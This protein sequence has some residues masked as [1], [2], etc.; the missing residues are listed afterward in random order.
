MS[1]KKAALINAI[2][3]YSTIIFQIAVNIILSRTLSASEYGVVAV[4]TTFSTFFYTLSAMGLSTGIIQNKELTQEDIGYIYTFS[5]YASLALALIFG[6]LSYGIAWFYGNKVYVRL[7]WLLSLSL[8]FN[9][10]N[11]VPQ[12]IMNRDKRFVSLAVRTFIVCFASA[13]V[14]I[15]LALWEFG[16]YAIIVQSVC[17][18]FIGF[19]WNYFSTQPKFMVRLKW[20]SVKKIASYSG[21]QMGAQIVGYFGNN[22]DNLLSGKLLGT[23]NLGYYN[24]AYTLANYPINNFSAIISSVL[25]PVLADYQTDKKQLYN[26][27]IKINRLFALVGGF[28]GA[29]CYLAA[30]EAIT[31][32]FGDAWEPSIV[33]F[34][35]L[36][37]TIV[38][39]MMSSALNAIYQ[40]LGKTNLLFVEK[41]V[42]AVIMV[43]MVV[44]GILLIGDIK[45]LAIGVS[46][47]YGIIYLFAVFFLCNKGF[48]ISFLTHIF[49]MK[50]EI[51]LTAILYTSV[52]IY[53]FHIGNIWISVLIKGLYI[54]FIF[55]IVILCIYRANI[56]SILER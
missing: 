52:L 48:E 11:M 37:S 28:T 4:I 14:A 30:G 40:A 20:S 53:P 44:S 24:K 5:V 9:G 6:G 16:Y 49:A 35:I 56:R 10:M 47:A 33:C 55:G 50:R 22:M 7:G 2:G 17:S 27:H 31:I 54:T 43:L 41:I 34:Q 1:I 25:H 29:A 8:L 12:G 15:V 39:R 51:L 42:E 23:V 36:G 32:L 45:G 13:V 3:K 21:F 26:N 38:F 19:L 18:A 46:V